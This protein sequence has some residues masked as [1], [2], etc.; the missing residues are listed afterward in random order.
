MLKKLAMGTALA[1]LIAVP[2]FAGQYNGA[3]TRSRNVERTHVSWTQAQPNNAYAYA[4]FD[5][6]YVGGQYVGQDPDANVRLELSQGNP[7]RY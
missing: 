4:G 2:A 7:N 5:K 1:T 3:Q 6:V